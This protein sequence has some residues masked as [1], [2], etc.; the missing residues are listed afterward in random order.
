MLAVALIVSGVSRIAFGVGIKPTS[1]WGWIVPAGVLSLLVGVPIGI[2]RPGTLWILCAVLAIDLVGRGAA[3]TSLGL[4][5]R[6]RS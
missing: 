3:C 1:G 5:L 6:P 4:A 2:G